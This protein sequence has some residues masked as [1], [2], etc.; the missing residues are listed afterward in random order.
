M[1]TPVLIEICAN[2]TIIISHCID[3]FGATFLSYTYFVSNATMS[4]LQSESRACSRPFRFVAHSP[5]GVDASSNIKGPSF[6]TYQR[7]S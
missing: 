7:A 4:L 5:S 1:R 2:G 6:T 3:V